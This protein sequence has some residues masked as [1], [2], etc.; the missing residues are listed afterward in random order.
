MAPLMADFQHPVPVPKSFTYQSD[1]PA[2]SIYGWQVTVKRDVT[3]F[4]TLDGGSKGFALAGSGTATVT[5]PARY[6]KGA[7]YTATIA[8]ASGTKSVVLKPR[9]R[10]LT[11]ALPL[12][13]SNTVQEYPLDGPNTDTKVFTTKVTITRVRPKH[14]RHRKTHRHKHRHASTKRRSQ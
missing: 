14:R 11:I 6:R 12:G 13:P 4:S 3:E 7:R 2:Y 10:R 5:T 9:R 1:N 8:S